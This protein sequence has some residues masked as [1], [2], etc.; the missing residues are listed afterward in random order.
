M[1]GN[2]TMVLGNCAQG[3]GRVEFSRGRM[4]SNDKDVIAC[5]G[6]YAVG[7]VTRHPV[8]L[9]AQSHSTLLRENRSKPIT[10]FGFSCLNPT[11]TVLREAMPCCRLGHESGRCQQ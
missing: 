9:I 3:F 8:F 5:H 10:H 7:A 4:P 2:V 6:L 1:S 11:S